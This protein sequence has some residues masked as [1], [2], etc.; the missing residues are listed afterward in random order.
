MVTLTDLLDQERQRLG[1]VLVARDLT[2]QSKL[3]AE[4]E[5]LRKRLTQSEKLVA[6]GQFVA[7]I[8]HELNNPLQGVLG[9]LELLRVTGAL[10]K[11]AAQGDADDLPRGGSRREDRAQSPRVRRLAAAR[12]PGRLAAAH[13]AE[14]DCTEIRGVPCGGHRSRATLWPEA[15]A[16]AER[17]AAAASG[18]PQHPDERRAGDRRDGPARAHRGHRR[19]SRA[20]ASSPRCATRAAGFRRKR[21]LGFSSRSTRRRKS[22]RAR[23]SAWPSPTASSRSTAGRSS[24]PT[25]LTAVPCSPSIC[26]LDPDGA[27]ANA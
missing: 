2:P 10:P 19:R 20:I 15:A 11:N 7:G 26:R 3:E 17:S 21:C 16:R 4:R 27:R 24:R 6:L 1:T 22:A 12:A 18:V 9:H 5:Q 8:A 13:P 23:V 25:I 14:G